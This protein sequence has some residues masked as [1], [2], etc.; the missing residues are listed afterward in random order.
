MN[1]LILLGLLLGLAIIGPPFWGLLIWIKNKFGSSSLSFED[2][3]M[4]GYQIAY[5]DDGK[6][7]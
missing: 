5:G 1:F 2:A 6:K 7:I 3:V 4:R